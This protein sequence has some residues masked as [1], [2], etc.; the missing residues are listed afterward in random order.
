MVLSGSNRARRNRRGEWYTLLRASGDFEHHTLSLTEGDRARVD[1]IG[2]RTKRP[3]DVEGFAKLL[4]EAGT[5]VEWVEADVEAGQGRAIRFKLPSKHPFE[6]Y[7]DMEKP[8]A[9][10]EINSVLKNQTYK[11]WRKG[12]SPRRFDH[13]NVA[14][15]MD[16]SEIHQWL[17]EKLGFKMREYIKINNDQVFGGWMSVT[18]LVH[19]IAVMRDTTNAG[20]N[21][22]HHLAYWLDNGQDLL[23]AADILKENGIN[24]VGPGKHG[25]TQAL[26]IYVKDPGSGHRVELFN[27][28]YLIF[29]P[30]WEPIEWTEE[31]MAVGLTYWG[32]DAVRDNED[33]TEA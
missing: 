10:E 11:A 25:I 18:P 21:R 2:W 6:I 3:E 32:Q 19:D 22:L 28:S 9:P 4:E 31:D 24:F 8:G 20:P 23:R 30:D 5:K 15:T 16:P 13:V 33:T 14:T 1:H 7:Y 12:I 17:Q 29:E 26:Y 27:G